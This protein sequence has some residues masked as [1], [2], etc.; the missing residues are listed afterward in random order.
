MAEEKG[1][2]QYKSRDGQEIKLSFDT[3]LNYLVQGKKELVTKQELFYFLGICKSRG[4]NP[5]IKDCYLIKYGNDPAQII[6][7]IDFF[8]KRA[9][10]QKDCRGWQKGIIVE[11][12]GEIVYSKGL[13]L[14]GDKLL[15]GWFKAQPAGWEMP[16]ELEVN[17]A[18]Y[19]K[20]KKD[21]TITQFWREENQ[22]EQIKK[23]A[24]SQGLRTVWPDEFQNLY[25]DAEIQPEEG[26]DMDKAIELSKEDFSSEEVEE[27][28]PGPD[29]PYI[30]KFNQGIPKGADME[31]LE[32][33]LKLCA[34]HFETTVEAFKV[35]VV[36]N[37][38]FN[39]FWSAFEE[40]QSQAEAP[41]KEEKPDPN[42]FKKDAESLKKHILRMKEDGLRDFEEVNHEWLMSLP[43]DDP[44]KTV[45]M[46][47]WKRVA[48][49]DYTEKGQPGYVRP[50]PVAEVVVEDEKTEEPSPPPSPGP[51]D[52]EAHAKAIAE[53]I[54]KS[55]ERE[56]KKKENQQSI[57]GGKS[58]PCPKRK[59]KNVLVVLCKSCE[60][61]NR[62]EPF[63]EYLYLEQEGG[64]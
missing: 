21:G 27:K 3:V 8:R 44:R 12:N 23:V 39:N 62:C 26:I 60:D 19:I 47:K 54:F 31:K 7:S 43:E 11:R 4:L 20:R 56:K 25:V 55:K 14:E 17:L 38:E 45:F 57:F 32:E 5:F 1:V 33:Y 16:F 59:D 58:V 49:K 13:M 61:K 64:N 46:E 24:E 10:A 15:G 51:I 2:V 29:H 63:Q 40:W 9:R 30:R 22:P 6:T 52:K 18:P 50:E 34:D 36:E 48:G 37:D 35:Q 53:S 42:Y 41:K 28:G